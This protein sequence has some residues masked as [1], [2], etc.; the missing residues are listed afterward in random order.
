VQT[1][2]AC[3]AGAGA[4]S[5]PRAG[6]HRTR[7]RRCLAV[8]AAAR[9]LAHLRLCRA[10]G[11]CLQAKTEEA[12]DGPPAI[13]DEQTWDYPSL[14]AALTVPLP[15]LPPGSQPLYYVLSGACPA[16]VGGWCACACTGW[17]WLGS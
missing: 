16:A 12:S 8:G 2:A 14:D 13:V 5:G 1:Q 4:A 3:L 7:S 9:A 17:D 6:L 10:A 11:V 15:K